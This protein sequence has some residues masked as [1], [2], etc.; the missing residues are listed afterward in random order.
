MRR[1]AAAV[2]AGM[3]L[4]GCGA[5]DGTPSRAREPVEIRVMTFNIEWGGARISFD[6][7]VEAI[8]L[9]DADIVGI[10]EAEGNLERLAR[11]LGWHFDLRNYA[12]SRF[13]LLEPP[14][15]D[16]KYVLV[17]IRPN[18]V[19]ALANLHLPS[20]PSGP[21]LVRDGATLADVLANEHSARIPALALWLDPLAPLVAAGLPVIVTGDFNS[22]A[23]TDWTEAMVG[24]RR[25][26]DL[27]VPWPVSRAMTEAGFRDA[28]R[29]V[30]PDPATH[31]GLT[32]W[33]GRPPL[34]DYAPGENDPQ[35]RIDQIW[36]AGPVAPLAAE[37]IGE[38]GRPDVSV[39]I[40]PWPSD[41]RAVVATFAIDPVPV[42]ALV[43]TD[44]RVY[45]EGET[46]RIDARLGDNAALA[47]TIH[48]SERPQALHTDTLTPGRLALTWR[49][50]R[51]GAY[52]LS[53]MAAGRAYEREFWVLPKGVAPTVEVAGTDNGATADIMV[54][55]ANAPG[56]R[57]DYVALYAAASTDLVAMLAWTYVDAR[58]EGSLPLRALGPTG[59]W[60]LGA[61]GGWSPPSG[62]YVLRLMK[63]DGYEA[64]AES[65]VFEIRR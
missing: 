7:V 45:R 21:D 20:D 43:T 42:P 38:T 37:I 4:A 16:G 52:R 48:D 41:H 27:A 14:G 65:P 3:L 53:A 57:N 23:H 47:V 9:A 35:V 60:W 22:P 13:P 5:P 30:F 50:A 36:F 28:W 44:R 17:E 1:F 25:F 33:A 64:L 54:H 56:N 59:G 34:P 63:D 15:A 26:L 19:L 58:P 32:W 55:W 10:Q 62:A 46:V 39:G 2:L 11:E 51:P 31:P 61:D 40:S 49:P 6:N 8:K 12:L 24:K 29:T 18:E